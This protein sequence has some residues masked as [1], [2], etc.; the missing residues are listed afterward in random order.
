LKRPNGFGSVDR[1]PGKR[2]RPYRARKTTGYDENGKQIRFTVGYFRTKREAVQ[3]LVEIS[4]L[5]TKRGVDFTIGEVYGM[6][7][8]QA[9]PLY[10]ENTTTLYETAYKNLQEIHQVKLSK[11]KMLDLQEVFDRMN[12]SESSKRPVK[13][14]LHAIYKYALA[15]EYI[16]KDYSS[17]IQLGKITPVVPRKVFTNREMKRLWKNQ[18]DF[19][20]S[21]ILIMIYT[22]M[23]VGEILTLRK[24][25]ID[26]THR[27]MRCGIK[28]KA[29]IN[30]IVPI[31]Q[32]ISPL[33]SRL[34]QTGPEKGLLINMKY[35]NYRMRFRS[36]LKRIGLFMHTTHDCRHTFASLLSNAEANET[37]IKQM[38]GHSSFDT[39]EKIYIH[40]TIE[41]LKRAVD[42]I[43]N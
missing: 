4:N 42:K 10:A 33:L 34:M 20:V 35:G 30:R 40:K 9:F 21:T 41:D 19:I 5:K 15:H 26:L 23:R 12:I 38:M 3:A 1:L 6:W 43:K 14:L 7:R 13:S 32:K 29:G 2:R 37:A 16:D 11:L 25:N 22:G 24:E 17:L 39:T 31:H 28:T 36:T 8:K 18:D 27:Y